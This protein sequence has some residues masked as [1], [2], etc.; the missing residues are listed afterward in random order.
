MVNT[1]PINMVSPMVAGWLVTI[2]RSPKLQPVAPVAYWR[3]SQ[4]RLVFMGWWLWQLKSSSYSDY[5]YMFPWNPHEI[6]TN[7]ID[8]PKVVG[9]LQANRHNWGYH[10]GYHHIAS[11]RSVVQFLATSLAEHAAVWAKVKGA[12]E[13]NNQKLYSYFWFG[14]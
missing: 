6:P 1:P 13:K 5:S 2:P 3:I 11:H 7:P 4:S 14:N 9:D 10:I 12:G 8:S